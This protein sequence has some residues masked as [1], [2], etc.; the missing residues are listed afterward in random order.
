MKEESLSSFEVHQLILGEHEIVK[1]CT[2][3]ITRGSIIIVV[4]PSGISLRAVVLIFV[5]FAAGLLGLFLRNVTLFVSGLGAGIVIGVVVALVD[6]MFRRRRLRT[7]KRLSPERILQVSEKNF[8]IPY[9]K[10]VKVEVRESKVYP[11]ITLFIPMFEEHYKYVVS[12]ITDENEYLFIFD[13]GKLQSCLNLIRRFAP[14]TIE[15]EEDFE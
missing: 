3:F 6:F 8:E 11:Q 14:K 4:P 12:F 1:P 15:I 2:L 10:I 9:E 7:M 5:A 13:E